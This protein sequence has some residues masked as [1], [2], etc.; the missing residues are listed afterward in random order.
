MNFNDLKQLRKIT[1]LTQSELGRRVGVG[2]SIVAQW[3]KGIKTPNAQKAAQL[4]KILD[5]DGGDLVLQM[6]AILKQLP[7]KDREIFKEITAPLL[8]GDGGV[9]PHSCFI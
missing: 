1:G 4:E 3:E 8:T 5:R 9:I 6:R 2:Q 7:P